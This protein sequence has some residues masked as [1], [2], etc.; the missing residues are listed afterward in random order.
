[1]TGLP[2]RAAVLGHPI[3][4]SLSPVLH[5]AAYAAIGLDWTYD[6][7]DVNEGGLASFLA[8]AGDEWAG[9]SLTMPLKVEGARLADFIEPQAKLVGPVN[10]L[11]PS[12]LGTHRQWVG[13]NTDIYGI[14]HAFAEAGTES[15]ARAVIEG[16]GATAASALAAF[17]S[18]GATSPVVLV[19]EKAR[20]G[21]LLR[22]ASRMGLRPTLVGIDTDRAIDALAAAEAVVSTIP[23][24][25]GR[26]LGD[27]LAARGA[28][29]PG[30]LLDVVYSPPVTPLAAAWTAAGGAAVSGTRM[31]LHQ[32]G[33]QI[34]LITGNQAPIGAMDAALA[35]ALNAA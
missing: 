30:C 11:I 1:M 24:D 34:R 31:L 22:V 21:A 4:H 19:R 17:G 18:M 2:R 3:A 23:A 29:A 8:Q 9:L 5:R 25:A 32:A 10:T 26:G 6:A 28:G 12:G 20:A 7:I 35:K 16:G 27:R 15:A 13:A 14:A 33:E